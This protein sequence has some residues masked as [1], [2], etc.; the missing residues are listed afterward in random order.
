[1]AELQSGQN[2]AATG[3]SPGYSPAIRDF[4]ATTV[5]TGVWVLAVVARK[6]RIA[7]EYPAVRMGVLEILKGDDEGREGLQLFACVIA[8]NALSGELLPP[9]VS[10]SVI[11]D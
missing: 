1:M 9:R 7:G 6:S 11:H 3:T 5:I 2:V 4:L 8:Y 10:L